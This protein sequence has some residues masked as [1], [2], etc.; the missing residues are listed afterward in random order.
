MV[1]LITFSVFKKLTRIACPCGICCL[2]KEKFLLELITTKYTEVYKNTVANGHCLFFLA[3]F[4][5]RTSVAITTLK[6]LH[7][8]II[9][10]Y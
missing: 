10:L 1:M 6:S 2:E 8:Y 4:K 9:K 3:C 7:I 5:S